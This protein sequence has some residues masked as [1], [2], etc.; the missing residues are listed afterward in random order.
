MAMLH[1][2]LTHWIED[3]EAR[4]F[5]RDAVLLARVEEKQ[6]L[7]LGTIAATISEWWHQSATKDMLPVQYHEPGTHH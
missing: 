6:R 1:S 2:N 5:C 3:A 4:E 7:H